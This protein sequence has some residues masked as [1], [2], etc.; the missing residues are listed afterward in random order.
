M[1]VAALERV[2]RPLAGR[3]LIRP[4]E[5][6][7]DDRMRGSIELSEDALP[8]QRAEVVSVGRGEV[9]QQTGV[10]VPMETS[11]GDIVLIRKGMGFLP[12]RMN[13]EDLMMVR[14]ADVEAVVG[15]KN[16]SE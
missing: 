3:I 8:T 12:V 13:G 1:K 9:A 6:T 15:R 2:F 11:K 5:N 16:I 7:T 4:I 14:E 10:I